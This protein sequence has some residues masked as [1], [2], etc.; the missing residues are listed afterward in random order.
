MF[1]EMIYNRFPMLFAAA[2]ITTGLG[3]GSASA[4]SVHFKQ[5]RFPTFTDQGLVLNAQGALAGL[6]NVDLVILLTGRAN[7]TATCTNPSGQN[8]PP[9]QNPAP[10]T[11][12][13]SEAIPASA[14][15]NGTVAFNVSTSPPTG[16]IPGAPDCPNTAVDRDDHR[17]LVHFGNVDGPAAGGHGRSY[18]HLHIQSVDQQRPGAEQQRAV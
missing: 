5:N 14:I 1:N 6:G 4:A 2:L 7:V 16:P 8:Q 15:K 9:G 13:G 3:I 18:C 11:V 10:I 17:S 12:A